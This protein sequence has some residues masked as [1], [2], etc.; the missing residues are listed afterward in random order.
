MFP[1]VALGIVPFE[2]VS[3]LHGPAYTCRGSF[4]L[5]NPPFRYMVHILNLIHLN[6]LWNLALASFYLSK[7][8]RC[9][10]LRPRHPRRQRHDCRL[11]ILLMSRILI[12]PSFYLRFQILHYIH[13]RDCYHPL[14][15][16]HRLH[17]AHCLELTHDGGFLP[18]P[19][20]PQHLDV[21]Q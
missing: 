18:P 6:G 13:L 7:L 2:A 15:C 11:H 10:P 1:L 12:L 16:D 20:L 9:C 19:D 17:S 14:D 3:Q 4:E 21:C 8:C 5:V